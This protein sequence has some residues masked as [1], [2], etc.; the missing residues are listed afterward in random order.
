MLAASVVATGVCAAWAQNQLPHWD[1]LTRVD[2]FMSSSV[3][4]WCGGV[5]HVHTSHPRVCKCVCT[6][7]WTCEGWVSPGQEPEPGFTCSH[8]TCHQLSPSLRLPP[9]HLKSH[10]FVIELGCFTAADEQIHLGLKIRFV[11]FLFV[12]RPFCPRSLM[13]APVCVSY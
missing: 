10:F 11:C 3:C 13:A 6:C 1:V 2:I 8:L 5:L 4:L 7:V 9:T 12:F